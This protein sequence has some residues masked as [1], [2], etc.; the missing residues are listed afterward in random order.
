M[1]QCTGEDVDAHLLPWRVDLALRVIGESGN[2]FLFAI[3]RNGEET[4]LSLIFDDDDATMLEIDAGGI[5][6]VGQ[7]NLYGCQ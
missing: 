1:Q 5:T 4:S 2:D 7:R 6:F 3:L